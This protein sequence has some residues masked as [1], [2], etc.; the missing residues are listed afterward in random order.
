MGGRAV[1][2]E[3]EQMVAALGQNGLGDGG[4]RAHG[5]NG[6]EG[7]G[8]LQPFQQ[9]RN[10]DD[11][12]GRLTQAFHPGG[13]ALLEQVRVQRVDHV[14]QGVVSRNVPLIGKK[15]TQKLQPQIPP[16]ADFHEI[17]HAAQRG[18]QHQQ[19]DFRQRID[20]TQLLARVLQRR[21]MLQDRTGRLG[22]HGGLHQKRAHY[23][24]QPHPQ[25]NPH[26][27]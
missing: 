15:P 18:A 27:R 6:D 20:H 12:G 3:G 9:P 22:R 4:L 24:S 14:V 7:T 13:K 26:P 1:G 2:L 11:V 10:G 19:E 21:K 5:V 23:E 25:R 16:K 17:L 8:K